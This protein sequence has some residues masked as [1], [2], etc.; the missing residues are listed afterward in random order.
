MKQSDLFLPCLAREEAPM[1]KIVVHDRWV[2][3][4]CNGMVIWWKLAGTMIADVVGQGSDYC[5]VWS[6][7]RPT[8]YFE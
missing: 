4:W 5:L 3:L 1:N 2:N 7:E 6:G 8:I